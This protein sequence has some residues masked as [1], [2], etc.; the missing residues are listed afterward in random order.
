[1]TATSKPRMTAHQV[2]A[3]DP[4]L[5]AFVGAS[6][7]TGKTHVL[8]A[9]V[10]RLMLTGT[11][12][13][14]ILCLTYTKAAAA[15]MTNR[16][17]A[18]L[19]SWVSMPDDQLVAEINRRTEEIA[20][21]DM[22]I[23]ARQL[24]ARVLDIH[25]GM[26]IQTFHSF[27][28]SLLGRFPLEANISPGFGGMEEAEAREIMAHARDEMLAGVGDGKNEPLRKAVATV[29]GLVSEQ[30]FDEI[31]DRL[32]FLEQDIRRL[33]Q[34]THAV[35]G[36][37]DAALE[38][39][40]FKALDLNPGV[41]EEDLLADACS[42]DSFDR[43]AL[44]HLMTCLLGGNA[45]EKDRGQQM[46]DFLSAEGVARLQALDAYM[47]VFLTGTFGPRK[48]VALK[49]TLT[50]FPEI[51][52][53]I[54]AEQ[55]RLLA[56]RRKI[57]KARV[58]R[59]THA[60]LT[61][62]MTQMV[63][64][65]NVKTT[66][67]LLD[68]DDMIEKTV[69]LL[70]TNGIAPW[71]LYKLDDK[72]DHILV[73]EAQDTNPDQWTVV[74][75]LAAEFFAGSGARDQ[76][77]TIFAVGDEKQSI[78]SFQKADPREFVA[79]RD[80]VFER[81]EAAD[82]SVDAVPLN[83]SFRSGEAVL[84]L[85]D[86]VFHAQ[87]AAASG[88]V[89]R[90]EEI[91]HDFTRKG[92]GG[93]VE[94][95]PLE[96]PRQEEE[97]EEETPWTPPTVQEDADDAEER[98]AARVADKIEAIIASGQYMP[99][100]GR[101]IKAGDIMVLVR[102][103]SKFVDHLVR[104]LKRRAIPVAGKDRMVLTD[105]LPVEDLIAL[106]R[107]TLLP[108]DD[109]TLATVLKGP[110][111]GFDEDQLFSLAYG[112]DGS[113]WHALNQK[114]EAD[115]GC[116]T[117]LNWLRRHLNLVD[118]VTPFE[119]YSHL[120]TAEQGRASLVKRLG[121]DIHDPV[122]EFLAEALRY[123]SAGTP[124]MQGF[125][126]FVSSSTA[127]VKRD[128]EAQADSV[129]IM[130]VHSSKGLQAPIV[131]LAGTTSVP[132]AA[133]EGRILTFR[134]ENGTPIPL[135]TSGVGS[136]LPFV[137]SLKTQMK[138]DLMAEYQRLLYV[139]LTRAEDHLY[140]A[141]WQGSKTPPEGCWAELIEAGFER[142]GA[143]HITLAD[144]RTVMRYVVDH[145]AEKK[146]PKPEDFAPPTEPAL[147]VP[148]WASAVMP[149]EPSPP[150]PLTPSRPDDEEP[151]VISPLQRKLDVRFTRGILIHSLLEWLPEVA[152]DARD[153]A[154]R[155]YADRHGKDL[156]DADREGAIT[157]AFAIMNDA[158]FGPIFG[159]G[160]QAEVPITGVIG[161]RVISGQIDRLCVQPDEVL[162]VDY[163]TNRPPPSDPSLV[164]PAYVKQ[165]ALY[166]LALQDIY[167]GRKIRA[168]LLWTHRARLMELPDSLLDAAAV[169]LG[170]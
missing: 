22:V 76:V 160:S 116:Q 8:T 15:E 119:F 83:L 50:I 134:D 145:K 111:V 89:F 138:N 144:G 43:P 39:T 132:R 114:A 103:R 10:L 68:F 33:Q 161:S 112:R 104:H 131:F 86:Q 72:I 164:S 115:A 113:L 3:T 44:M 11:R 147:M 38:A 74:E 32:S 99:A 167:P 93:L 156:S 106:G 166:R 148:A 163:K 63:L 170:A 7:G 19:G 4:G 6:A 162:I 97:A 73:D 45:G 37:A 14:N 30:T 31:F 77:R 1:M 5:T 78:F 168:A 101:T 157:E 123:E 47:Q 2:L 121:D 59:A 137:D 136:E 58:A 141:G 28:Q 51:L 85:V 71:V 46:A 65:S 158:V 102:S 21:A 54:E 152:E 40:I 88:L 150:K 25:G 67:G 91:R 57:V 90:G 165:M 79:A 94:L 154:A 53:T 135:W 13:E 118:Q 129:R 66:R 56:V 27:C 70:S 41:T 55:S 75:T 60:V 18:E 146:E 128:M 26:K 87:G 61:L 98:C 130:T 110:F 122:D 139:A 69:G 49:K 149:A 95:W 133:K 140:V 117:A 84:S 81:A 9:R 23:L 29:A 34:K 127:V 62:A 82:L 16:I 17:Y 20:D 143:E 42:E 96:A 124:S 155:A 107:F 24:F 142:L 80:R 169:G 36:L 64:Y 105:E 52:D 48:S 120:L 35:G 125:L 100:K 108:E 159:E 109:L 126:H 151:A 153:H 12:P 92:H